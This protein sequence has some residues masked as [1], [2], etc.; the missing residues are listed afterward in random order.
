MAKIN[1]FD[2]LEKATTKAFD[3]LAASSPDNIAPNTDVRFYESLTPQAFDV[4]AATY[5]P[6]NLVAYVTAMEAQRM[7]QMK[8]TSNGR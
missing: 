2:I 7:K 6:D 8:G 5:G 3:K 1:S 4:I